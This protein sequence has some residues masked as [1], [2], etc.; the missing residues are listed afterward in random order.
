MENLFN[1][2]RYKELLELQENGNITF[3]DVE[4]LNYKASVANQLSYNRKKD[5]FILI[6]KYLNRIITLDEFRSKFL[7]M[8]KE[9]SNKSY[10][11]LKDFKKLK[12]FTLAEK[13]KKFS[14]LMYQIST[15][16][17]DYY[18]LPYETTKPMS[19]TEFYYLVNKHYVQLQKDFPFRNFK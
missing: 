5:Y 12:V 1:I 7:E 11:I 14:N 3:L 17:S 2:S 9:D 6:D 18:E 13:L 8:E 15:L 4:L 16:C 19:E 10:I